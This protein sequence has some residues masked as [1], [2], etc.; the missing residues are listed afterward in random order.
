MA[1]ITI[2]SDFRAP[3]KESLTLFPLFP[4]LFPM[5]WWDQIDKSHTTWPE[6]LVLPPG[7]S[8]HV[9][10]WVDRNFILPFLHPQTVES[11]SSL[12]SLTDLIRPVK[13]SCDFTCT[14]YP[15]SGFYFSQPALLWPCPNTIIFFQATSSCWVLRLSHLLVYCHQTAG[16]GGNFSC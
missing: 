2:C 11:S 16:E 14:I 7:S 5:K 4:H 13:K 9:P 10:C 12:Y 8:H 3:K 15:E 6:R 1:A